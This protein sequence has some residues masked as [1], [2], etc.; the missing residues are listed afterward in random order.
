MLERLTPEEVNE[1]LRLW[2]KANGVSVQ[3]YQANNVGREE[4]EK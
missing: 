4:G 2:Q 3:P 1:F